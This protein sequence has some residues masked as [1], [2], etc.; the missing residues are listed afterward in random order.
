[1]PTYTI[2][3]AAIILLDTTIQGK[4]GGT[5]ATF[6]WHIARCFHE[7]NVPCFMAGGLTPTNVAKSIQI[8]IPFGVDVSSG[9]ESDQ[10]GVKDHGLIQDFIHAVKSH[11]T[12][13]LPVI[14]EKL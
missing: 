7:F 14:A 4:R 2:E 1:M 12:D 9:I 13:S 5:G 3:D 6:D 8:G 11:A 10:P